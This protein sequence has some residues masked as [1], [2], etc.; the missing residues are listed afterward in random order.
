MKCCFCGAEIERMGNNPFPA[1]M[2]DDVE[3]C[4]HCNHVIVIPARLTFAKW[5][6]EVEK[7]IADACG[8]DKVLPEE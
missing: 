6:H 7:L 5:T 1:D 3:C 2:R 8:G 4:D